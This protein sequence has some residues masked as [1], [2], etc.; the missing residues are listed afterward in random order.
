MSR[1]TILLVSVLWPLTVLADG[2]SDEALGI[3][4]EYKDPRDPLEPINRAI[5]D[6]NYGLDRYVL[7]PVIHTYVDVVPEP[8]QKGVE[9]FI[10]NLDEPFSAVNNLL[11]L[12][13][14]WAANATARFLINSTVGVAGLMDIAS[15]MGLPRK[16][17]EFGEVLGYWGV[18]DGPYLM[19]PVLGPSS[20]REE[21]GDFVDRLYF[22]YSLMNFWQLSA[23]WALDGLATRSKLIDQEALLDNSLDPYAFTKEAYFQYIEFQL[24][25]GNPPLPEEDDEAWLDDYLDDLDE[26]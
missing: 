24:Y 10:R 25:D 18:P 19:L 8:G 5:W 6:F 7:R 21:A 23:R 26:E 3:T 14:E 13:P 20:L 17:D 22:P 4:V 12:K 1:W 2:E 16:Q 9:N 15:D 11:Q